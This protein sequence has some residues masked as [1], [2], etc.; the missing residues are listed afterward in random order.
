MQLK[1]KP[2]DSSEM[3]NQMHCKALVLFEAGEIIQ[4]SKIL[5]QLLRLKPL[6][7]PPRRQ[8]FDTIN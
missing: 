3:R 7:G 4:G 5:R 2:N 1:N 6:T 8:I